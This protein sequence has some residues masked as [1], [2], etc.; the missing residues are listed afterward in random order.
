ME[1]A[2][3]EPKRSNDRYDFA[4]IYSENNFTGS[5]PIEIGDLVFT[6]INDVNSYFFSIYYGHVMCFLN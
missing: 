4:I 2:T 5:N 1:F 6:K 3:W